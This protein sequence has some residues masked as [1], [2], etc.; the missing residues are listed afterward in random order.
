MSAFDDATR[1]QP[2][3]DPG[4]F[5]W[6][7]PDGWQQGRGAW[8]GLPIGAMVRAVTLTESDE[9][10]SVR[11]VS[12]QLSAPAMV[13]QHTVR[14]SPVRVGKGMSTWS[15][16]VRDAEES[17]V[18]GGTVITGAPRA[19]WTERDDA[20]WSPVTPPAAPA[21]E[22]IPVAETPPP[23][24]PFTQHFAY[25][26]ASGLPLQGSAAETLG[27]I[28]YREAVTPSDVSLIA[29]TD[30]WYS[31]NLVPLQE[32]IPVA[33]V[34]F[35]ANL[36]VDPATLHTGEPLLHHGLVSG[37]RDGYTSEQRRLWTRDGRLA[38]DTLQ[39]IVVG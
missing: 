14:V 23:F 7:V 34:N 22:T 35:T 17:Y 11:T 8:G 4:T 12:L 20:G 16:S 27:W 19:W 6:T 5:T 15:V 26:V 10:R 29:L 32:L 2:T 18:C 21:P 33:T 28:D 38:A 25:R 9:S 13:G 1:L 36:L 37:L 30:A 31:V 39:T 24:P 3:A